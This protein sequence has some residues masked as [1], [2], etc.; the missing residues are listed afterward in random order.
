MRG[1]T[2]HAVALSDGE[3]HSLRTSDLSG[4]SREGAD[5]LRPRSCDDDRRLAVAVAW[6]V[7]LL[8]KAF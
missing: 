8:K 1:D 7:L 2:L 6:Q 3:I 4:A 5:P